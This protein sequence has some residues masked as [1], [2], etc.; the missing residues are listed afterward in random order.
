MNITVNKI[1]DN[2]TGSISSF[3]TSKKYS[4]PFDAEVFKKLQDFEEALGNAQTVEEAKTIMNDASEYVDNMNAGKSTIER[5]IPYLVLNKNSGTYHLTQ[6][7]AT[8]SVAIPK[9]FVDKVLKAHEEQL[10]IEPFVKTWIWFLRNPNLNPLKAEN[11]VKYITTEVVDYDEVDKLIEEGYSDEVATQMSTYNDVS[12]TRNGLLSTYKYVDVKNWKYDDQGEQI[13]RYKK[14]LVDQETGEMK[15]E[16]PDISE[17]WYLIPPVMKESGDACIVTGES[18][19]T[20]RVKVGAV[21]SLP[22]WSYVNCND[23][24]SCVKGLKS[25][26]SC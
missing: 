26:V 8:S 17:D 2:I 25:V 19:P 16:Y 22:D 21:H 13:E 7:G 15:V 18:K 10:P 20:H 11:F 23:N 5:I 4:V 3:E 6:N 24:T 9:I 1:K 14:S 12:I